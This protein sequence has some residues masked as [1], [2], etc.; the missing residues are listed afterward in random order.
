MCQ[1][2][3]DIY[4]TAIEM[5]RCNQPVFIATDIEDDPMVKFIGRREDLSQFGK[6]VKFSLLHDLEP[7]L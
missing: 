6:G 1:N 4:F 2:V 7:T 3:T 5:D